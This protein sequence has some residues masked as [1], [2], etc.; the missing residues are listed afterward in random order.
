M[1]LILAAAVLIITAIGVWAYVTSFPKPTQLPTREYGD[2]GFTT[3]TSYEVMT[4]IHAA[5]DDEAELAPVDLTPVATE[6]TVKKPRKPRAKKPK[7]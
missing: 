4:L 5:E 6:Q 3:T 2:P 7:A 1:E